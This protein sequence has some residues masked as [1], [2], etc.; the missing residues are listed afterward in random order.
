MRLINVRFAVLAVLLAALLV[1]AACGGESN[2]GSGG[3]A[4][5]GGKTV[6]DDTDGPFRFFA[7]LPLS[8][9]LAPFGST[10]EKGLMAARDV[11]NANGGIAGRKVELEIRDDAGDPTN[12][13]SE[14]QKVIGSEKR[15]HAVFPGTLSVQAVPVIPLTSAAKILSS[16]S[17]SSSAINQPKKF[18][19]S[20]GIAVTEPFRSPAVLSRFKEDGAKRVGAVVTNDELGSDTVE[21]LK[22]AADDLGVEVVVEKID[23]TAVDP[24][25]PLERL[26]GKD[27]DVLYVATGSGK[28]TLGVVSAR[29]KLA[30]DVP[31]YINDNSASNDFSGLSKAVLKDA[32]FIVDRYAVKEHPIRKTPA[33]K[34]YEEAIGKYKPDTT[35]APNVRALPYLTLIA[36]KAAY[37][38]AGT[39]DPDKVKAAWESLQPEDSD[40]WFAT[41]Q[42]GY[43]ATNHAVKYTAD[44]FAWI[45]AAGRE[46]GLFVDPSAE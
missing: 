10:Q 17:A 38:K 41:E 9:D 18:P 12:S 8:G 37:D 32:T 44:D 3:F 21:Q 46:D 25:A 7:I 1:F 26:K 4:G 16:T 30:W 40:L 2:E 23:P 34:A 45:P 14:I 19:Y 5:D 39:L 31:M 36:T 24:T 28:H 6:A 22:K 13:V 35:L 33:F 43:S 29:H 11:I 27:P 42:F 15:P 20:F